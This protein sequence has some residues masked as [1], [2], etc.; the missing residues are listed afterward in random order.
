[1]KEVKFSDVFEA[2][3]AAESNADSAE[4][5]GGNTIP[6]WPS[7]LCLKN[8]WHL[9]ESCLHGY[10]GFRALLCAQTTR[11]IETPER[12]T[13]SAGARESRAILMPQKEIRHI[14]RSVWDLI[15]RMA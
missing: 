1:M 9:W 8:P 7:R 10:V 4:F 14:S 6:D 2:P 13:P 12:L 15:Y 11:P 3:G 5:S